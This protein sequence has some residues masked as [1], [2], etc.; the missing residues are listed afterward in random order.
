MSCPSHTVPTITHC[1]SMPDANAHSLSPHVPSL[2]T[3][4]FLWHQRSNL[5][6]LPPL[7]PPPALPAY[8]PLA[9]G[10]VATSATSLPTRAEPV[11]M[12]QA[13]CPGINVPPLPYAPA[14][15]P[16][17][18]HLYVQPPP[19]SDFPHI[20]PMWILLPPIAC[21]CPQSFPHTT[22]APA[23]Y[24]TDMWPLCFPLPATN[25]ATHSS[26]L[27]TKNVVL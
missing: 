23:Q 11:L 15:S 20:L 17:L 7:F 10:D 1:A 3:S 14:G 24:T 25:P 12:H 18:I 5:A 19:K 22:F 8:S 16:D 26:L 2:P 9:P 27:L 21:F 13:N 4:P 6:S